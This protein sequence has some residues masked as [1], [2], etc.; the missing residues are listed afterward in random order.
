MVDTHSRAQQP[1]AT[2]IRETVSKKKQRVF[3]RT[4]QKGDALEVDNHRAKSSIQDTRKQTNEQ[5]EQAKTSSPH[6]NVQ[7][8]NKLPVICL[9]SGL[10]N[11]ES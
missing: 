5:T 3:R 1:E 10:L 11:M 7:G 4:T 6:N 2:V 8:K 9:S